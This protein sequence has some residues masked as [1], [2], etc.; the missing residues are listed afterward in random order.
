MTHNDYLF[1]LGSFSG[2]A[3][4]VIISI[5][6]RYYEWRQ[7]R[8]QVS[9]DLRNSG[10]NQVSLDGMRIC[11]GFS[12]FG[13]NRLIYGTGSYGFELVLV[14]VPHP[15]KAGKRWQPYAVTSSGGRL[16]VSS[17]Q[18]AEMVADCAGRHD[19][20]ADEVHLRHQ[21]LARD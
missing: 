6:M 14:R 11:L 19:R 21:E 15:N 13:K 7:E 2:S 17:A 18:M 10:Y 9:M 20:L 16:P 12:R 3:A 1:L 5:G 4:V 8:R